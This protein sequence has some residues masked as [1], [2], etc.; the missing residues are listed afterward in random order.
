MSTKQ[1]DLDLLNDPISQRMLQLTV[2]ARFAYKKW[3]ILVLLMIVLVLTACVPIA[4][5]GQAT[6]AATPKTEPPPTP[7]TAHTSDLINSVEFVGQITGTPDPLT[8]P[9]GLTIDP[10]GHLYVI[11]GKNNRLQVFDA[12]GQ[13]LTTLG[14]QGHDEGQFFFNE[15]TVHGAV[16]AD[17]QGNVYIADTYNSRIQKFTSDGQFVSLWGKHS[18]TDDGLFLQPVDVAVDKQGNIYVLDQLRHDIQTFDGDGNFLTKWSGAGDN[19]FYSGNIAVDEQG[20]VYVADSDHDRVLKFDNNGQFL[21]EWGS[22]GTGDGQFTA[23]AGITVDRQGNVFVVEQYG[24]RVQK[25]DSNGQFLTKWGS[26]GAGDGQFT[27]P[28]DIAVDDQGNI[29]VAD[30]GNDRVQHFYQK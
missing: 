14:S 11:D 24:Q 4:P 23:P 15:G 16:A 9:I 29:Y 19:Q 6:A 8:D 13:Y 7:T 30:Y 28:V 22:S 3:L 2:P 1:G 12:T 26:D 5:A 18:G 27:N 20:N 10:Q 25:F 17:E 21:T